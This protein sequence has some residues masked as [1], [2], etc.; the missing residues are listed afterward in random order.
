MT[1]EEKWKAVIEN[2]ESKDGLFFYCVKSTGIFC[3]PSCKSKVPRRDNVIFVDSKDEAIGAGF[4]P[5]KRCR[6]DL[7]TYKPQKS[8]AEEIRSLTDTYWTNSLEMKQ[9]LR[10]I[11]F[12]EHRLM[13]IFKEEYGITQMEYLANKKL[14]YAKKMLLDTDMKIIDLAYDLDFGSL[15]SFYKFF[16][17]RT[18]IA[19]AAFRK[20]GR[21]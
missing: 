21:K 7:V 4:R 3:R 20:G 10:Q 19:P 2:D 16:K 12:S 5:C 9:K 8:V 14:E 13:E 6:S 15:S 17:T 1:E 18:G 11:G